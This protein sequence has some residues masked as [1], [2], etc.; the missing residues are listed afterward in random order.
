MLKRSVLTLSVSVL[1]LLGQVYN[2][3]TAFADTKVKEVQ[4]PVPRCSTPVYNIAIMDFGCKAAA[5][6]APNS[7]QGG[8]A[9]LAALFAGSGGIS[10]VGKGVA[11]MFT[12]ALQSTNCFHIIDLKAY[13]KMQ[14]LLSATGQTVKPPHIDYMITGDV[15]SISLSTSGG[16]L[17]A[18]LIPVLGLISER[19]QE[20]QLGVD[21]SIL[22]PNTA[23]TVLA[24]TF[25]ADSSKTSWGI[26]GAGGAGMAGAA[27]GWSISH[28]LSLDNVTRS[29]VIQ[30]TTYI[31]DQ[32]AG[33][34]ITYTPPPP[35]KKSDNNSSG[36]TTSTGTAGANTN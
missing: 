23:E 10:S 30:A 14:A 27:G 36:A 19:K 12:T 16:A 2:V 32:L 11:N 33:K 24:K 7:P 21:V 4:I 22:N 26:G 35:G 6:K 17:G 29:V 5:C 31:T 9:A 25:Q 18:G 1:G 3:S 34:Y 13:K 8:F 15:T 20:A 28:N